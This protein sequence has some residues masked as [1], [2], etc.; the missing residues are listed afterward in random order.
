MCTT[1]SVETNATNN[2]W[3]EHFD[4]ISTAVKQRIKG[5]LCIIKTDIINKVY[6]CFVIRGAETKTVKALTLINISDI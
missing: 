6:T 3:T 1:Q 2:I 5:I 4:E